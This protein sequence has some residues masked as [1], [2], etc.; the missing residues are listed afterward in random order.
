MRG[1]VLVFATLLCGIA[2]PS[3]AADAPKTIKD[4][5]EAGI[6]QC[7]GGPDDLGPRFYQSVRDSCV[8]EL[9]CEV[10]ATD[11]ASEEDLTALGCTNFFVIVR[12]GGDDWQEYE[13]QTLSERLYVYCDG[14]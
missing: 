12:C 3:H 6:Y 13:S 11:V 8:D 2:S 14:P 7:E 4:I 5:V 1:R 9:S 10:S